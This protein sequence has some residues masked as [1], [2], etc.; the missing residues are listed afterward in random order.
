MAA[1]YYLRVIGVMYFRPSPAA[2]PQAARGWQ[3]AAAMA[4]CTVAIIGVGLLPKSF[5]DGA[6]RAGQSISQPVAETAT[7]AKSETTS[8]AR[9]P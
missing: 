8:I 3:A 7:A 2:S 6:V 9:E 5:L 4:A 1:A